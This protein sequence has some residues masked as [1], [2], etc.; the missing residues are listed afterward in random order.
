M[1]SNTNTIVVG[2]VI[3]KVTDTT[4]RILV[5]F[6]IKGYITCKLFLDDGQKA[7]ELTL[8]VPAG[9]P[10]VFK[11]NNLKPNTKY[12]VKLDPVSNQWKSSFRT[13]PVAKDC[14]NL[15]FAIL[16]CNEGSIARSKAPHRDLWCDLQTRV[17]KGEVDYLLMIGDS[18]Y[19]DMGL[20]AEEKPYQRSMAILKNLPKEKWTEKIP[21]IKEIIRDE[22]RWTWSHP[23]TAAVLAQVPTLTIFDD[24]EIRD[25]WGWRSED[26]DP[27][28]DKPDYLFGQL[29]REAYYEYQRQ[30]RE[31]IDFKDFS[32]I[33]REYHYH[34]FG[35]IGLF[36]TDY[37]GIRTWHRSHSGV[38]PNSQLGEKQFNDIQQ[39]FTNGEFANLST[40]LFVSTVPIV[41]FT[42]KTTK[43]ASYKVDDAKEQWNY[44]SGEE[45]VK[46]FQI[47]MDWKAKVPGRDL[48]IIGGDIH[49]GGHTDIYCNGERAFKQFTT[50]A[51]NSEEASR[52]Q[53]GVIQYMQK[54]STELSGGYTFKHHHWIKENNYGL[55]TASTKKEGEKV[56][57]T[58]A[59]KLVS[60]FNDE[61]QALE[62]FDNHTW[63]AAGRDGCCNT[64]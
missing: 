12:H 27:N 38:K 7:D 2:P 45:Q 32:K 41:I 62:E 29:A 17:E 1:Q 64:F 25:D 20:K 35:S 24:H 47:F 34:V 61:M 40:V 59:C 30:L 52:V 60:Y 42:R 37:R 9:F 57:S 36:F 18:I 16:S 53:F 63:K 6:K 5:E 48:T 49:I 10:I 46:L 43:L 11:F 55:V 39:L 4:A 21:Q 56:T 13:L 22:Y 3:G 31:D 14:N 50:S 19:T 15:R 51:I 8:E 33:D 44:S 54:I 26:Y 28:S 58:I 23:F